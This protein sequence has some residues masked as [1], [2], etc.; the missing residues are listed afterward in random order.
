MKQ[1]YKRHSYKSF[2][3]WVKSKNKPPKT[4]RGFVCRLKTR[5]RKKDV[6]KV[7]KNTYG[8]LLVSSRAGDIDFFSDLCRIQIGRMR[9]RVRVSCA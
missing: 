3:L 4:R 7:G 2:A 8:H 1:K 5:L 9:I 6:K